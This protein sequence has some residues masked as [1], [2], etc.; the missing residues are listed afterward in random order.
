VEAQRGSGT[1][2]SAALA[3]F[4]A[5]GVFA[6]VF[7]PDA[8]EDF[9]HPGRD[10]QASYALAALG[11]TVATAAFAYSSA[12]A[13]DR[14]FERA[15]LFTVAYGTS[16]AV[17]K[18]ILSPIAFSK[19]S[20]T[21][22]GEVV[23]S[24]LAVVPVYLGAIAF[25]FSVAVRR[26]GE[27]PVASKLRVAALLGVLAVGTRYAVSLALGTA[28]E[29]LRSLVGTGLVLPVVAALAAWAVMEAFD[30]S[31]PAV[32]AALFE[33][34]AIVLVHHGLWIVYMYRLF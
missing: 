2:V 20:D 16:L 27:W 12:A 25:L 8:A 31:R 11:V 29:Y 33:A 30:R 14:G 3:V 9:P 18:F 21:S 28:S 32:R 6:V 19:M 1:A 7:L 17:V 13:R 10:D 34:V 4:V 24:G 26:T 23:T 5:L 22:L 15:W